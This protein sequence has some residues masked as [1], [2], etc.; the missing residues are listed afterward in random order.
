[1]Q[2]KLSVSQLNNYIKGVFDDELILKNITVFGEVSEITVSAGNAFFT[3]R[4]DSSLLRCVRF[5][6]GFTPKSGDTVLAIGSVEYYAKGGRVTFRA[7]EIKPYGEGEIARALAELKAKLESEGLFENRPVLPKFIKKIAVV[8]STEGAV[9][10]DMTSILKRCPYLDVMVYPVRVQGEGSETDVARAVT[11]ASTERNGCDA[12]ILARGGGSE[13]DLATFNTEV[14]AR[15]VAG[16]A[17]PVVSAIGHETN[18]TLCDFCAGVRAGTPSIAAEIV[19]RINENF[20]TRFTELIGKASDAV[21][22]KFRSD[23][24]NVGRLTRKIELRSESLYYKRLGEISD[25]T[26]RAKNAVNAAYL[27]EK[28]SIIEAVN[29]SVAGANGTISK[30]ESLLNTIS[31]K[32]NAIS[33]L[34]LLGAGYARIYKGSEAVDE[35]GKIEAGD[36]VDVALSGGFAK[37]KITEVRKNEE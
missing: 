15:A 24:D 20:V 36:E 33:P 23:A 5:G 11:R 1:M 21:K 18:Y 17:K 4:D 16:S 28:S 12:I 10:H 25:L 2:S 34:R 14:S 19:C 32:L 29:K 37:A 22:N 27:S 35:I 26:A 7:R 8:T 6:G 30:A 13:A 3:L 9:I 31:A